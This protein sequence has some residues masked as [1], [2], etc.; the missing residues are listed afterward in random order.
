MSEK[1]DTYDK[2][3]EKW[4]GKLIQKLFAQIKICVECLLVFCPF[5]FT[6]G[7][8]NYIDRLNNNL[9]W[10]FMQLIPRYTDHE[11]SDLTHK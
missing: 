5:V 8:H 6:L 7:C 1:F 11:F 9:D 4:L 3:I 2:I 10:L